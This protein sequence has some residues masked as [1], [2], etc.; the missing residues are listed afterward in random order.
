MANPNRIDRIT[1]L[2]V[3]RFSP[4]QLE[5]RDQ[6]DQHAGHGNVPPEAMHTH[7]HILIQAESLAGK[8]RVEQHREIMAIVKEEFDIGL[9]ALQIQVVK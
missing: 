6:S 9:H 8:S 7:L 4:S 5:I 2:L 3:E 1:T